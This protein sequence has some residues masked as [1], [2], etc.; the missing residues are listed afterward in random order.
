MFAVSRGT[1]WYCLVSRFGLWAR[2]GHDFGPAVIFSWVSF[3]AF[4]RVDYYL[5]SVTFVRGFVD[6][7]GLGR[8][9]FGGFLRKPGRLRLI[10]LRLLVYLI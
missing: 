6:Q 8:G 4:L 1:L 9:I 10:D 7:F 3:F 2:L 5:D